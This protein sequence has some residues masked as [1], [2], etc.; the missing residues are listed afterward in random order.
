MG[1]DVEAWLEN[2]NGCEGSCTTPE[3]LVTIGPDPYAREI[4]GD[5]TPRRYCAECRRKL[6]L[7]V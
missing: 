1:I 5:A 6:A 3:S 2:R 7:E 4:H